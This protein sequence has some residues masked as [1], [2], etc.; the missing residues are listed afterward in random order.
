V[1]T[2]EVSDS[3]IKCIAYKVMLR[4]TLSQK[5]MAIF[6]NKTTKVNNFII[7]KME[8]HKI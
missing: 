5:E 2:G 4:K 7:K 3:I 1:D 6:T 8:T